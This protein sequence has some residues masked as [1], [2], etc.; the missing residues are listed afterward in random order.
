MINLKREMVDEWWSNK[1]RTLCPVKC[2]CIDLRFGFMRLLR[3]DNRERRNCLV[4][5]I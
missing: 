3:S 5:L 4:K 2:V 1:V